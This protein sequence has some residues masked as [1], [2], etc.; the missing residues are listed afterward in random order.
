MARSNLCDYRDA[1]I[2]VKGAITVPNTA[3]AGVAVNN[4]NKI[5]VFKKLCSIN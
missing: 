5:V 3:A 1:Y 2:P 4:T